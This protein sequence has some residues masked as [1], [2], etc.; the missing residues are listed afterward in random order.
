[1]PR[2]TDHIQPNKRYVHCH[3]LDSTTLIVREYDGGDRVKVSDVRGR[4]VRWISAKQIRPSAI[5]PNGEPYKTG[6]AP[7]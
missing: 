5:K 1:M 2:S 3:P 7:A 6:Y 4:N